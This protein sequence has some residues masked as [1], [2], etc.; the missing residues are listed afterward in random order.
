MVGL[1]VCEYAE[2]LAA[3]LHLGFGTVTYATAIDLIPKPVPMDGQ[4]PLSKATGA[5]YLGSQFR[6]P[7]PWREDATNGPDML[8]IRHAQN[9]EHRKPQ[10]ADDVETRPRTL[11]SARL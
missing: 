10:D 8:T 11:P 3:L 1:G 7:A 4:Q 9:Q 6:E 2:T 5:A